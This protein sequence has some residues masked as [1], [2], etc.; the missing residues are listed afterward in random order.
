MKVFTFSDIHENERAWKNIDEKVKSE[1]PD[2]I[3]CAGDLSIF[4]NDIE[5]QM[6]KLSK[7]N[8]PTLLIHGNHE[9]YEIMMMLSTFHDNIHFIHKKALRINN[10]LF[11]GYGGDGFSKVDKVFE[12]ISMKF[13]KQI[14]KDDIVILVTHG[15]PHGTE[16]DMLKNEY[17]G[18]KSYRR[19]I[20]RNN[21]HYAISGHIHENAGKMDK[22]N[23]TTLLNPGPFGKII[24]I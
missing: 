1:N 13:I 21:I 8:R 12:S 24:K 23:G 19:F 4:E 9:S 16:L 6:K 5:N 2:L 20:D 10:Y 11:L 3:I 7:F 22:I 17:I 15:P 18:N 14:K